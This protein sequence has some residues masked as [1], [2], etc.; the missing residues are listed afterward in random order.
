MEMKK[1][2]QAGGRSVYTWMKQPGDVYTNMLGA[3]LM[4]FG[5]AQ[6]VVGHWRLATGKGKLD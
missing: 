4:T 3:G 1:A 2:H 6:L 5:M